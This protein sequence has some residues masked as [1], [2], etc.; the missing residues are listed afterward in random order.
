[1]NT[2]LKEYKKYTKELNETLVTFDVDLFRKFYYK[3][4][5]N[6]N[7]Q[8]PN[9]SSELMNDDRWA[10]GFMCKMICNIP[11]MSRP[12][13]SK[14]REILDGYGWDYEIFI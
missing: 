5:K 14:A 11:E 3:Q 12:I 6:P 10:L 2:Y 9:I 4:R 1:M 13:V 8:I 7:L